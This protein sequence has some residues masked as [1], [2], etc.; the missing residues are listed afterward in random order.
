MKHILFV[1]AI[2]LSITACTKS[3]TADIEPE[4]APDTTSKSY[5]GCMRSE[6]PDITIPGISVNGKI[7]YDLKTACTYNSSYQYT[8]YTEFYASALTLQEIADCY[9]FPIASI[10]VST[11][12]SNDYTDI[13]I[14]EKT[15]DFDEIRYYLYNGEVLAKTANIE[16]VDIKEATVIQGNEYFKP[17]DT[18][19]FDI[20]I[21]LKYGNT[22]EI[23]Y[24]GKSFR[25]YIVGD[26]PDMK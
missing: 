25:L 17:D 22:I 12:E 5:V 24:Y 16:S 13:Y 6:Y 20:E 9:A 1:L 21:K 19:K 26:N 18:C 10:S 23:V 7:I 11:D 4:P 14:P 15:F 8:A 3:E 2:I